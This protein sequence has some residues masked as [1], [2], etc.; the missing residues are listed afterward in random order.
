MKEKMQERVELF[1]LVGIFCI[2]L[3][4]VNPNV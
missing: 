1:V 4:G 3:M 2:S